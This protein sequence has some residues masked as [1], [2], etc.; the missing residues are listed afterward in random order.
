M[1]EIYAPRNFPK[2]NSVKRL[3]T[4]EAFAYRNSSQRLRDRLTGMTYNS[5][6]L[7]SR[8]VQVNGVRSLQNLKSA[9]KSR[10]YF[11][12][13]NQVRSTINLRGLE[14]QTSFSSL[15]MNKLGSSQKAYILPQKQNNMISQINLTQDAINAFEM[16]RC[17]S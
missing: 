12:T 4:Q 11:V 13:S 17:Q 9:G 1:N 14:N 16:E 3:T 10:N 7:S 15:L 8:N 2:S 5:K 6:L